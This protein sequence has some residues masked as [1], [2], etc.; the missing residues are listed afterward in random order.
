M[1]LDIWRYWQTLNRMPE[2][3]LQGGMREKIPLWEES[4]EM[5]VSWRWG[6][7][8]PEQPGRELS[9]FAGETPLLVRWKWKRAMMQKYRKADRKEEKSGDDWW[10]VEQGW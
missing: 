4:T 3:E 6:G 9:L 7:G 5:N 8:G 10:V 2:A 1:G